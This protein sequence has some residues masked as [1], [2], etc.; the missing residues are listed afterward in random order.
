MRGLQ[1][2][3]KMR[4]Y[5]QAGG[6][7]NPGLDPQDIFDP[8]F[9]QRKLIFNPNLHDLGSKSWWE[10]SHNNLRSGEVMIVRGN[11]VKRKNP[12]L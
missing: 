8:D 3:V 5:T 12:P 1:G 2:N 4:L 6:W 11:H 7:W 9:S 10:L